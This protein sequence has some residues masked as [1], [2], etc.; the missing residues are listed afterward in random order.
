LLGAT[1]VKVSVLPAGSTFDPETGLYYYRAR[2]Y[3]PTLGRFLQTDPI[4]TKD[5]LDLY[6]YVYNDPTDR[7]DPSGAAENPPATAAKKTDACTG[8]HI[9]G[10]CG[11]FGNTL[12]SSFWDAVKKWLLEKNT[13]SNIIV[14]C[15]TC[16][17]VLDT[18]GRVLTFDKE[19]TNLEAMLD[20]TALL[21]LAASSEAAT[22]AATADNI[23]VDSNKLIH[24]FGDLGHNLT[25]VVEHFGSERAAFNAIRSATQAAVNA[26]G[27]T[28][29]FKTA[30]EV[31]GTQVTVKGT[32]IEGVVRIGT[33]YI[34]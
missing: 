32:V 13:Y 33:A 5:D 31:A 2:F 10:A 7:V 19:S 17:P 34:P 4:G 11:H 24:I 15:S 20:L 29:T 23:A 28:G 27:L 30:V 1:D 6:T 22:G 26:R 8:T 14:A 21:G 3:S 12:P 16:G 18:N 25:P 9:G